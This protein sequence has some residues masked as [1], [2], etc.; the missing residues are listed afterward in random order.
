MLDDSSD[1]T[2]CE[3]HG[4][5]VLSMIVASHPDFVGV[6]PAADVFMYKIF[7]CAGSRSN[8]LVIKGLLAADVDQCDIISVSV[9]SNRGY[10]N[11]ILSR[12]ASEIA[13]EDWPSWLP[14]TKA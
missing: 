7:V 1:I 10:R 2:D 13:Q 14:V 11:S 9:G 8:D 5:F 12:I 3:G 4:A 6:G